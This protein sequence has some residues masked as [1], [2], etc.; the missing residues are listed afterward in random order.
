MGYN[1][2][3]IFLETN[4]VEKETSTGTALK[5]LILRNMPVPQLKEKTRIQLNA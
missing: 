4:H 3:A 5:D 1:I 2:R